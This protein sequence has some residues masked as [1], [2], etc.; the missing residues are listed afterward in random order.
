MLRRMDDGEA[1]V[2]CG[3][4]GNKKNVSAQTLQPKR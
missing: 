1:M 4:A 2:G 3:L